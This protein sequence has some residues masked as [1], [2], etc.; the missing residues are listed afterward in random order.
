[1]PTASASSPDTSLEPLRDWFRTW[2][3]HVRAVDFASARQ[4]FDANVASFGT[5]AEIVIGLDQLEARQWRAIW[6][7][8]ADFRFLVERLHGRID[9]DAAWAAVPWTSMGFNKD[10]TAFD[11]PGRATVTYRRDGGRWLGL[12]THFSLTPG[13]PPRTYGRGGKQA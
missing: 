10:S 12:H 7:N 3:A 4:L 13:I 6:P 11:R 1:M 2:E 9:G 8:I 5:H